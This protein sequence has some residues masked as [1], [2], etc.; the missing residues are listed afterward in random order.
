MTT[1]K[2]AKATPEP[3]AANV[4][5]DLL[6]VDLS[7]G[8]SISAPVL[9]FPRLAHG[10]KAERS[11]L[12]LSHGGVHWPDLNEDIPVEGLLNGEKSEES[13][14][15]IRRWLECRAKGIPEPVPVLVIPIDVELEM[16]TE[17]LL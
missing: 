2:I 10:T 12:E 5:D 6:I 1:S 15:S 17:G 14:S 8:R 7:D 16:R 3:V 13:D 4:T 9:W 11:N